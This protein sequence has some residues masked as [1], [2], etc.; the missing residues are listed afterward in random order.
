MCNLLGTNLGFDETVNL[1]LAGS[2]N[3]RIFRS[4]LEYI[5]ENQNVD[6]VILALTFWDRVEAPWGKEQIWVDYS[7]NGIMR[8]SDSLKYDGNIFKKYI[9]DRFK[10]DLDI[11][12]VDLLL[13]SII[14]FS[15]WL[16]ANN[17]RHVIF[18]SPGEYFNW[19]DITSTKKIEY[20]NSNPHI[21]DIVNWSSNKHIGE[22]DGTGYDSESNLPLSGKHYSPKSFTILNEFLYNYINEHKL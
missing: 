4:T 14:T 19:L 9:T 21:I 13:N 8:E 3:A 12:Y 20:I 17:I 16:T 22:H 5:I 18:S 7:P 1:S 6:F 11:N 15:G 10:F 2:S